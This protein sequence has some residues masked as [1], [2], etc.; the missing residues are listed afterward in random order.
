MDTKSVTVIFS[1]G[2]TLGPVM[3]LISVAHALRK[4]HA[5]NEI[6]VLWVGTYRGIERAV[7]R[8]HNIEYRAICSAKLRRYFSFATFFEPLWFLVGCMQAVWIVLTFRPRVCVS[9]G[10]FVSVPLHLAAWL[11]GVKTVVHHQDIREGIANKIMSIVATRITVTFEKTLTRFPPK[12]TV[13]TGNPIRESLLRGDK[14]RGIVRFHLDHTLPTVLVFG[15]GTGA[16]G[17]NKLFAESLPE[18]LRFAQVLNITGQGKQVMA[19]LIRNENGDVLRVRYHAFEFLMDEEMGDA[20]AIADVVV[21]RAGIGSVS[22]IATLQKAAILIPMPHTHQEENAQFFMESHAAR[23][24]R[25]TE[26]PHVLAH[27]IHELIADH[28]EA[29]LLGQRAKKLNK[30]SAAEDIA[31]IIVELISKK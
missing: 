10:G 2:G 21:C 4:R 20:Y 13:W 19:P 24:V 5:D 16:L 27:A 1:G 15:G 26:G 28:A 12:K 14:D 7:V 17:L 8:A 6:N 18:V 30:P 3:P 9:A 29:L 22:E 11:F 23:I 25:Q 31:A